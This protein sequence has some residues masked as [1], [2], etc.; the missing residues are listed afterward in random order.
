MKKYIR[1]AFSQLTY[2]PVLAVVM[3][4]EFVVMIT[5]FSLCYGALELY[6]IRQQM[7]D[8]SG[9]NEWYY[10]RSDNNEALISKLEAETGRSALSF[11]YIEG[12]NSDTQIV[13]YSEPVFKSLDI[14]VS[15]GESID[16]QSDYGAV[17]CLITSGLTGDHKVGQTYELKTDFE[18]RTIG[19][20]Y[21]C[22]VIKDD[23]LFSPTYG[24]D[25]DTKHIIAYDPEG[26]LDK[27]NEMHFD[28]FDASG[29]Y[30]FSEEYS[31]Y[32]ERNVLQPFDYYYSA[33][34]QL[35]RERIMPYLLMMIMFS[36]LSV[37]GLIAY[38]IATGVQ[39]R[40][41]TALFRL[42]GAKWR[43]LVLI[44]FLRILMIVTLPALLS[45]FGRAYMRTTDIGETT[46]LSLRGQ[47][48]AIGL[49]FAVMF[50][51]SL[52]SVI[53]IGRES[54]SEKVREM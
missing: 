25:Y 52:I 17:P 29:I 22:G 37:T 33:R 44:T 19:S 18:Q 42:V 9:M 35:E 20:V 2:S 7:Y 10:I 11:E 41:Q 49:C 48:I 46:L 4:I 5:C 16:T 1:T 28:V 12:I 14:L 43:Q 27:R 3:C 31:G 39:L 26:K 13:V 32:I 15:E 36:A 54:I 21:I 30:G 6:R 34:N 45:F 23:V 38:G 53:G 51:L 40:R 47:M 8:E 24:F 50:L